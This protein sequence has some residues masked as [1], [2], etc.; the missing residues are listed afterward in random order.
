[1][2]LFSAFNDIL[3]RLLPDPSNKGTTSS[4]IT[5]QELQDRIVSHFES[6]LAEEST[7]DDVLFPTNFIIFLSRADY[8]MRRET[9][10][11]TVKQL[12]NKVLKRSIDKA[13][14][15]DPDYQPHSQYWQFQFL[16][17]P[18]DG[19]I[20]NR[21]EKKYGLE[22][23]E[24]LIQSTIFP[25]KDPD[26]ESPVGDEAE[27]VVTTIHTKDSLSMSNL[28][29]NFDALKGVNILAADKFRVPYGKHLSDVPM[30]EKEAAKP[31]NNAK[32]TLK[33]I[34]GGK[35]TSGGST[36]YMTTDNLYISGPG[37][38]AMSGGIPIAH[39]DDK[40][41]TDRQV[42]IKKEGTKYNLYARGDVV[43]EEIIVKPDGVSPIVLASGNQILIN[44]VIAIDF[45]IK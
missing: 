39:I 41:V 28:A 6:R 2:S 1:M 13:L 7:T 36:F 17:F 33:I 40:S 35:F 8:E 25:P 45:N 4:C 14:K 5:R 38:D 32:C 19:F 20:E 24:V 12:V 10:A 18:E 15:N 3:G 30:S 27:H 29:I 16:V 22:P 34:S 42:T 31:S 43:V 37:S 9:F 44:G 26:K 21:G 11:I 23:K